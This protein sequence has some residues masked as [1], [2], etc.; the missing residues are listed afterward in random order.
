MIREAAAADPEIAALER[1]RTAQ[2]LSNYGQAAKLLAERD[3]LREGMTIDAAGAAIFAVGHPETYRALV[4]DGDW[5]DDDW[6]TWAQD[7][8]ER[9]LLRA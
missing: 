1:T 9:T 7:T 5:N 3:A 4:V 6:G 8:L 2:R